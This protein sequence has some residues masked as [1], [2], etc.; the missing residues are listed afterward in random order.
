MLY[1][2]YYTSSYNEHRFICVII[3]NLRNIDLN[4]IKILEK[5][6]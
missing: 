2:L 3:K 4:V 1:T 6:V 5:H